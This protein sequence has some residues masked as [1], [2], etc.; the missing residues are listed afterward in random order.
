M[1]TRWASVSDTSDNVSATSDNGSDTSD[2][3]LFHDIIWFGLF[4]FIIDIMPYICV[5]YI[6]HDSCAYLDISGDDKLKFVWF[7]RSCC[8]SFLWHDVAASVTRSIGWVL[9]FEFIRN[10]LTQNMNIHFNQDGF[11]V[12]TSPPNWPNYATKMF[13]LFQLNIIQKLGSILQVMEMVRI[14][15]LW[16]RRNKPCVN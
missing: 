10:C 6:V 7:L 9:L 13:G 15:F 4:I 12:C 2:T 3:K 16:P 8:S 5:W 11:N 1:F 14:Y